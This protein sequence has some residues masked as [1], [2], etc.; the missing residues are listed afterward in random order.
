MTEKDW[1]DAEKLPLLTVGECR[2]WNFRFPGVDVERA[3]EEDWIPGVY[4][5]VR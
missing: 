5:G 1:L 2:M 4:P 3:A